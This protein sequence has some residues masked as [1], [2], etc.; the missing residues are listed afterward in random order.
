L[1]GIPG[2]SFY[3]LQKGPPAAQAL[4]PPAG[5]TVIDLSSRLDNLETTAA[6]ISH[7]DLVIAVDTVVVHL[8]GAMAKPV[9]TLL[10]FSPDWRWMLNRADT[11]WYPTMRL[12]RLPRRGDWPG[13]MATVKENLK[14]MI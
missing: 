9:W 12:F 5:M 10:P 6:I 3:S 11:P 2:V 14:A 13:V 8:A 4:Q 7:L 1:A